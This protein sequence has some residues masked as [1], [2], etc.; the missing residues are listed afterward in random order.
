MKLKTTQLA[1]S[2][3]LLLG[4]ASMAS[5]ADVDYPQTGPI[6]AETAYLVG[7]VDPVTGLTEMDTFYFTNTTTGSYHFYATGPVDTYGYL[8]A[9]GL[10]IASNDD[11]VASFA[12]FCVESTLFAGE[13]IT[14]EVE[15]WSTGD[16]GDYTVVGA[17]GT[18]ADSAALGFPDPT[19]VNP[20]TPADEGGSFSLPLVLFS[21]L[22]LGAARL[23]RFFA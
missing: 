19:N 14:I 15:G 10:Q 1:L 7:G 22:G 9:D 4:S 3:S 12:G 11:G 2:L 18:C 6:F 8:L 21:L 13:V 16:E 20:N 23:R 17:A 5:A